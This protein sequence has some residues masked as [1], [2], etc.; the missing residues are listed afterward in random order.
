MRTRK[1]TSNIFALNHALVL[2]QRPPNLILLISLVA[3]RQNETFLKKSSIKDQHIDSATNHA[4][5]HVWAYVRA[6]L[7]PRPVV[8]RMV[9]RK[10]M[11][12]LSWEL[13]YQ[14]MCTHRW[15]NIESVVFRTTIRVCWLCWEESERAA[16]RNERRTKSMIQRTTIASCSFSWAV[17]QET[18]NLPKIVRPCAWVSLCVGMIMEWGRRLWT[19]VEEAITFFPNGSRWKKRKQKKKKHT[20]EIDQPAELAILWNFI[21]YLYWHAAWSHQIHWIRCFH[22]HSC[23][24]TRAW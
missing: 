11:Y 8:F 17:G 3:M 13:R 10:S 21:G 22:S 7:V 15:G 12:I 23:F 16:P 24:K 18:L 1:S 19:D 20:I 9:V 4:T 5:I 2:N 6:L 14:E